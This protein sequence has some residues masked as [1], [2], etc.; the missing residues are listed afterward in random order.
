MAI[1]VRTR[2]F[3]AL[4]RNAEGRAQRARQLPRRYRL[5]TG[6][7]LAVIH[8]RGGVQFVVSE[9]QRSAIRAKVGPNVPVPAVGRSMRHPRRLVRATPM[10]AKLSARAMAR[11]VVR[12]GPRGVEP[13][14]RREVSRQYASGGQPSWIPSRTWGNLVARRPTL[15]GAGGRVAAGWRQA[16]YT[17]R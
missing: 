8:Q 13:V 3:G 17:E 4:V 2:G 14:M 7:K 6:A 10:M 16:S 9:R 1:T 15:G 12:G 11:H 5:S